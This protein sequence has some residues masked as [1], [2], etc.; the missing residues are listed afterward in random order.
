MIMKKY[1]KPETSIIE[2]KI[3]QNLL[4]TSPNGVQTGGST[5]N[6]FSNEDVTYSRDF[7]DWDE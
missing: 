4:T 6:E 3:E 2:V 5:G 1:N 7:D